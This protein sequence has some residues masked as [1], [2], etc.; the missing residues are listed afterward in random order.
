MCLYGFSDGCHP[1]LV[2][3]KQAY[4]VLSVV[5]LNLPSIPPGVLTDFIGIR[6]A[7]D[8]PNEQSL[9]SPELGHQQYEEGVNFQPSE[10]H[11]ED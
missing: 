8:D 9:I 7:V 1:C 5:D 2:Q 6:Y 11:A 10:D 3:K 4:S